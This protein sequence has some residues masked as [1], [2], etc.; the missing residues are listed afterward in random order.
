MAQRNNE[1]SKIQQALLS[2]VM[3]A[4]K[5]NDCIASYT[6][7]AHGACPEWKEHGFDRAFEEYKRNPLSPFG[8]KKTKE[9]AWLVVVL[10]DKGNGVVSDFLDGESEKLYGR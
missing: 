3:E 5:S 2:A 6:I 1:L 8:L 10:I 7:G 4:L 9:Q